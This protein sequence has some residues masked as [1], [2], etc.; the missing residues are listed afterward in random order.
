MDDIQDGQDGKGGRKSK[1]SFMVES[2]HVKG[3]L[4][5]IVLRDIA[6]FLLC[7]S[8]AYRFAIAST[9]EGLSGFKFTDLLSLVLAVF[10]I[11]LSAAF[12]F[13]ADESSRSFYN[14]TNVFTK[15]MSEL[16]GRIESGFGEKL[17][18]LEIGY[19]GINSKIDGLPK[20]ILTPADDREERS[21]NDKIQSEFDSMRDTIDALAGAGAVKDV[22]IEKLRTQL[23]QLNKNIKATQKRAEGLS[24]IE[25]GS[26]IYVPVP[27]QDILEP[28]LNVMKSYFF[29]V[30][31]RGREEVL[32]SKFMSVYT[33][34]NLPVECVEF[35]KEHDL[36]TRRGILT[37]VGVHFVRLLVSNFI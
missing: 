37:D 16:L 6:V 23:D 8:V 34:I 14:N 15:E 29:P 12:Y 9:L 19:N 33:D 5:W 21:N 17:R 32:R 4:S 25:V 18:Q 35:L 28:I 20:M 1:A 7:L 22:E 2:I 36:V 13:K 24:V 11:A 10:A 30:D 3:F 26:G 27:P 31:R